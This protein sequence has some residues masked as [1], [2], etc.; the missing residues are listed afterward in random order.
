MIIFIGVYPQ[1]KTIGL[2]PQ[3]GRYH[4]LL[5][6][7]NDL[8]SPVGRESITD[9]SYLVVISFCARGV[10]VSCVMVSWCCGV[11]VMVRIRVRY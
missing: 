6:V 3:W 2:V 4:H 11:V 5:R 7:I 9:M 8:T 1:L 10:V